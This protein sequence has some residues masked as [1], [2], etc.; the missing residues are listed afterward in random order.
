MLQYYPQNRTG[1]MI[2]EEIAEE[3]GLLE[4]Y[5]HW[6]SDWDYDPFCMEFEEKFGVYPYS[7]KHFEYARGGEIQG[8]SGF[9]Y[10]CTYVLFDEYDKESEKWDN[11]VSRLQERGI[12]FEDGRWSELG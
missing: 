5:E 3:L 1:F 10:D 8:L 6:K 12:L 4:L 11:M 9:E 7:I 2:S